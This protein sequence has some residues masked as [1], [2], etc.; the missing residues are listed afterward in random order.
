MKLLNH[1]KY[2]QTDPLSGFLENF[3]SIFGEKIGFL[4]IFGFLE[5]KKLDFWKI[6]VFLEIFWIFGIFFNFLEKFQIF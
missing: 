4:E 3:F 1:Q 5:G 2:N 6:F